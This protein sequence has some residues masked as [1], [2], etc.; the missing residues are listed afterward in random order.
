MDACCKACLSKAKRHRCGGKTKQRRGKKRMPKSSTSKIVSTSFSKTPSTSSFMP[1]SYTY[2]Q[3]PPPP[4][5]GVSK[6][7]IQD[8]LRNATD[9]AVKKALEKAMPRPISPIS[10]PKRLHGDESELSFSSPDISVKQEDISVKQEGIGRMSEKELISDRSRYDEIIASYE[11]VRR[12]F[13]NVFE[14]E[15]PTERSQ[16]SPSVLSKQQFIDKFLT[17]GLTAEQ[18]KKKLSNMKVGDLP[19][20]FAILP[21]VR[22]RKTMDG[23]IELL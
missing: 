5:Q 12:D 8:M 3:P 7:E 22:F 11:P 6:L 21:T 10:H 16:I 15:M 17:S 4:M 13:E 9:E 18:I 23:Q 19:T 2:S 1:F 20:S 14:N